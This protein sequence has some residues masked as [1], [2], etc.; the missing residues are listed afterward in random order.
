[1]QI[2][3]PTRDGARSH[4]ASQARSP[5]ATVTLVILCN[6]HPKFNL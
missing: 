5:L 1:M 6:L 2:V 4:T 3:E